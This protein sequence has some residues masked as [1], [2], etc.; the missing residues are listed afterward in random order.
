MLCHDSALAS[1]ARKAGVLKDDASHVQ[2]V[3]DRAGQLLG[4]GPRSLRRPRPRH[5][6]SYLPLLFRQGALTIPWAPI[7]RD[8]V[9]A[10]AHFARTWDVGLILG[11]E[12]AGRVVHDVLTSGCAD[13]RG[14]VCPDGKDDLLTIKLPW[15]RWIVGDGMDDLRVREP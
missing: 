8:A 5:G 14:L 7:G 15:L 1:E 4:F 3:M 11:M 2:V 13:H 10:A 6:R 9:A 12:R